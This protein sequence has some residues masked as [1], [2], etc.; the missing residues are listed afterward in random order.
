MTKIARSIEEFALNLRYGNF[1]FIIKAIGNRI[2]KWMGKEAY[3]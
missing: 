3:R 1:K 2:R